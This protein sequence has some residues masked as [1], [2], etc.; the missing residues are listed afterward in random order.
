MPSRKQKSQ[1]IDEL[2]REFV[3]DFL[4]LLRYGYNLP[5]SIVLFGGDEELLYKIARVMEEE[6]AGEEAIHVSV[7]NG[8]GLDSAVQ[9]A[10]RID[11]D[12]FVSHLGA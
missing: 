12:Y 7:M 11:A 5:R 3:R 9:H 2:S 10:Y 4:R 6:L 1:E 8:H